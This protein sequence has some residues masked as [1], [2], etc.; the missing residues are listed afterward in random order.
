[1]RK[2][3]LK[4]CP[5]CSKSGKSLWICRVIGVPFWYK[6][7]HIECPSCHWCGKSTMFVWNAKLAW[8]MMAKRRRRNYG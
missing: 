8:N 7:W 2:M 5:N 3:K 1:M 4:P 6:R